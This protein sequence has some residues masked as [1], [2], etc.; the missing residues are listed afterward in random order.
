VVAAGM[1]F[2][3]MQNAS[4]TGMVDGQPPQAPWM[5]AIVATIAALSDVKVILRRGISGAPRIAR[6]LWRVCFALFIASGSLFLGQSQV[7]PKVL[8]HSGLLAIP[9]LAPGVFLIFWMLRVR[10]GKRFRPLVPA[11]QP[12]GA[13]A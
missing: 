12:T 10:L 6:H 13:S 2:I 7:F 3:A 8:Q 5:F 9:A 11:G 4:P 1:T